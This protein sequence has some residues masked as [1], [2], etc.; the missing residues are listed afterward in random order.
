G[1]LEITGTA[2]FIAPAT[3]A[4]ELRLHGQ[5][6]MQFGMDG[7]RCWRRDR[8]FVSDCSARDL[9]EYQRF[10]TLLR[11]RFLHGLNDRPLLPAGAVQVDGTQVPAISVGDLVLAFDPRSHLLVQVTT[12]N[13]VE[14]YSNFRQVD[15]ALVAATRTLF[16]GGAL[17][18][19]DTWDA[20]L[21]G[22]ADAQLL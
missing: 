21:P 2:S 12:G 9:V 16:I 3:W 11:L 22:Q 19:E 5:P 7:E 17:D 15:G 6:A 18:V 8:Q 13:R 10:G 1:Q 20:I 14:T 4:T